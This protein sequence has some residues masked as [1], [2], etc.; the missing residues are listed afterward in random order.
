MRIC[1]YG[2]GA[3]G[4][5]L[6]LRFARA[7]NTVSVVARGPHLAA[8]QENG[9]TVIEADQTRLNERVIATDDPAT[10][11]PQDA[12][13]VALK[14][15]SIPPQAE[16]IAGL[17]A[18]GAAVVFAINGIPWWYPHADREGRAA[19]GG[20]NRLPADG[21]LPRLDPERALWTAVRPERAIGCV[22]YSGNEVVEPGV[23]FNGT[24]RNRFILGEPDGSLSER[25]RRI[26]AALEAGGVEAP[27]T[28]EIRRE[29][30]TKLLN[31]SCVA[32]ISCLTGTTTNYMATEPELHAL[33][34]RV[35]REVIAVAAAHGIALGIDPDVRFNPQSPP[36]AHKSSMLQDLE[37]G[38]P[39]EIDAIV[40]AVQDFARMA[41]VA[42]PLLDTLATLL[43]H[44]AR[45]AGLPPGHPPMQ[46]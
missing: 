5:N 37:L 4:G 33:G 41:G 12:V 46:F 21:P 14:A 2:A 29:A 3:V 13:V 31:N 45:L 36:P 22:V 20:G 27:V 40:G 38:R 42:T 34:A 17:L 23:V 19:G 18:P 39:M 7:G 1:V 30:W 28:G 25:V 16:R 11:E 44:R 32:P 24:R 10:L 8:M 26:S 43:R 35:M 15:H 6:A 9:L